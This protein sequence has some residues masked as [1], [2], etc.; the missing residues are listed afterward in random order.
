M[1]HWQIAKDAKLKLDM[2]EI[3]VK[4]INKACNNISFNYS[5]WPNLLYAT[6]LSKLAVG[7]APGAPMVARGSCVG[8]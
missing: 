6:D 7:A 8:R 2:G 4:A 5:G 1:Q 3:N